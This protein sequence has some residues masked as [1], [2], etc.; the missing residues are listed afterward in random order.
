MSRDKGGKNIKKAA[1]TENK[2]KSS[3]YQ[4]SKNSKSEPVSIPKKK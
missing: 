2:K 1:S 3:Y 4:S